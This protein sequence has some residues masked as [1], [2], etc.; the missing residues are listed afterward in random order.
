MRR[1]QIPLRGIRQKALALRRRRGRRSQGRRRGG[2]SRRNT[3]EAREFQGAGLRDE[4][5][6][7]PNGLARI[8]P[9]A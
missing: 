7:N 3:R 8:F 4:R 6:G 2:G 1:T 9:R 5:R